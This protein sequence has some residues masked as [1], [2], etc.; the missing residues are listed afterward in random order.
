MPTK[1]AVLISGSGSNLQAIIDEVSA[2]TID[3]EIVGV[4]SNKAEAYGLTRAQNAQ[5]PTAV[6]SHRDYDGREGFDAAMQEQLIAWNAE[7]VV[8]AGFMRILTGEFVGQW[9]GKMLNVHPSLLPKYRGLNTHQRAIDAGDTEAGS[10]IHF[11]TEELDGGP[12][13]L[14]ARVAI[15]ATDDAESLASKVQAQEHRHYPDVVRWLCSGELKLSGNIP[16]FQGKPLNQPIL[17]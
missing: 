14:Q 15:A 6:I 17:K 3:A 9:P 5:I 8:L 11:V 2:G 13:V 4:L 10:S 1:I 16:A 12:I 7:V